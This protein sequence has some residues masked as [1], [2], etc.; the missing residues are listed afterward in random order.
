MPESALLEAALRYQALGWSVIPV[1]RVRDGRCS[2]GRDSCESPGKHPMVN[3]L[4]YQRERAD[5][6]ELR[7]WWSRWPWANIGVVTGRV[8]GIIAADIDARRADPGEVIRQVWGGWPDTPIGLTGGGGYHIIHA[9]PGTEV[10]NAADL[11]R[12]LDLRGDGGFIV[13]PPS[14]HPS[15]REY[16]W[17]VGHAPWELAPTPVPERLARLL[18]FRGSGLARP[19]EI[20]EV[21]LGEAEIVEG[22]RNDTLTRVAGK[23]FGQGESYDVVLSVLL[24]INQRQC[25]PPL[26]DREVETIARSIW[27]REL[28]KRQA[29]ELVGEGRALVVEG[30]LTPEEQEASLQAIWERLGLTKPVKSLVRY[31]TSERVVYVL[32]LGDGERVNLGEDLLAQAAVRRAVYNRTSV[33]L[34][35][36]SQAEWER[37][38]GQLG[39]LIVNEEAEPPPAELVE[40]WF[41]QYCERYQ[42]EEYE[43]PDRREEALRDGL[44]V[45][46]QGNVWVRPSKFLRFV[47]DIQG[48]KLNMSTLLRY[49]REAG[50][51]K[52]WLYIRPNPSAPHSGLTRKAWYRKWQ[53]EEGLP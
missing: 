36:L 39:P 29:R 21:L 22:Q 52:G 14:V 33:L 15:G 43:D 7:R 12:G 32:T 23:L 16:Q 4:K 45:I 34:H 5:E 37:L 51:R 25:R 49:M 9:H 1:H 53:P 48:Y 35:R 40:E 41:R 3:W 8:S 19:V 11:I 42:P 50:W 46:Y 47:E 18:R 30:V 44:P 28:R 17:E 27:R 2:C 13:V 31:Q 10:P 26:P 24:E 6:A 38:M 20:D